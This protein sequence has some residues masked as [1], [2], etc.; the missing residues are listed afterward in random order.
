MH[1]SV[2]FIV[3]LS[4]SSVVFPSGSCF[5]EFDF[6]S[7]FT[8]LHGLTVFLVSSLLALVSLAFKGHYQIF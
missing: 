4:N 5:T 7:F 2:I 3:R 1:N 8:W 6:G